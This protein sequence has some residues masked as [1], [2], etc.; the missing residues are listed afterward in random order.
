MRL[1]TK[2]FLSFLSLIILLS[3]ITTYSGISFI[4]K[5]AV[6]E[7]KKGLSADLGLLTLAIERELHHMETYLAL[8]AH[9]MDIQA[10]AKRRD[11]PALG[12]HLKIMSRIE[13]IDFLTFQDNRGVAVFTFM[14]KRLKGNKIK[15]TADKHLKTK[16]LTIIWVNGKERPALYAAVPLGDANSP[17]GKIIAFTILDEDNVLL[18]NIVAKTSRPSTEPLRI[19]IFY[20]EKRVFTS[21]HQEGDEK[22]QG[23]GKEIVDTLYR[24]GQT[25]VGRTLIGTAPYIAMYKPFSDAADD[26]EWAYGIGVNEKG[27][28][29]FSRRLLTIFILISIGATCTVIIVVFI[30]TRGITPSLQ[31]ITEACKAIA[32]GDYL[33]RIDV[34]TIKTKEFKLIASSINAM[35]EAITEREN[36]I[37]ENL[38]E[39]KAI[40]TELQEK[41]DIIKR[42]RK[43]L[44]TIL[45][46]I[47]DGLIT[48][49]ER[50]R[51]TYFN[52]AAEKIMGVDRYTVIGR[53]YKA[54][55]PGVN[56]TEGL[57]EMVV[58]I[59]RYAS[60]SIICLKIYISCFTLDGGQ[61]GH[62]LLFRDISQEKKLEEFKTDFI[63]SIAHDIKSMLL[64]V[65]G[66]LNRILKGAYGPIDEKVQL[67]LKN[68]QN[69]TVKINHL[70]ENYLNV[71]KIEAGRL[72][73]NRSATD[74]VEIIEEI[75]HMYGSRVKFYK[76]DKVPPV[77]AD[78]IYIERVI[79]N[80]VDN[81]IK[82]SPENSP[83]NIRIRSR[84]GA[85]EV[86][87]SDEGTGIP[88]EE[89]KY[90]FEKYRRGSFIK[91]E[92]GSGLGL[93]IA[94]SI[95]EAHGGNI[96]VE[97]MPGKGSTFYFTVPLFTGDR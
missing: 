60:P 34:D 79:I 39:I 87:V 53:D 54:F 65:T 43:K 26:N 89:I 67:K 45:E 37:E 59:Q 8:Y 4:E 28:F 6:N 94:R 86:A 82:F 96:W 55:F 80:L 72:E 15:T 25:Y 46:T 2:I 11:I 40:N 63:S 29:S 48:L 78:R 71:S 36:T 7:L 3:V 19:S 49:D 81:A 18:K 92:S 47:D 9:Q 68:I 23:L 41:T 90:I 17:V 33:S 13:E 50:E 83:V 42:E 38:K 73:L 5:I 35:V 27:F 97:S 66:F 93:F 56:I 76:E 91:K 21:L 70:V 52:R 31:T 32:Q 88:P 14:H 58:E 74:M 30:I 62:I 16:G 85:L 22:D 64:P 84:D 24:K 10:S 69:N 44:L 75:V 95:I 61:S 20:K 77:F 51:V 1:I 12:E 57:Q